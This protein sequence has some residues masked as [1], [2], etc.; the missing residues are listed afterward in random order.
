MSSYRFSYHFPGWALASVDAQAACV[1]RGCMSL[2]GE[3]ALLDSVGM[4]DAQAGSVVAGQN[5]VSLIWSDH[6]AQPV[7]T[8]D[9]LPDPPQASWTLLHIQAVRLC[10]ALHPCVTARLVAPSQM[11]TSLTYFRCACK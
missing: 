3:G 8:S 9:V 7:P 1:H 10:H 5:G 4:L 2:M 11:G 6:Q